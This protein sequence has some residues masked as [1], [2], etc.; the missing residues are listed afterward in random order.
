MK[1]SKWSFMPTLLLSMLLIIAGVIMI[2][3]KVVGVGFRAMYAKASGAGGELFI[4]VG[5]ILLVVTY[6]SIS[7]FSK[8]RQLFEGSTRR[9]KKEK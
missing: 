3:K 1:D 2:I 6:F 4:F 8:F 9:K 7:P 5:I